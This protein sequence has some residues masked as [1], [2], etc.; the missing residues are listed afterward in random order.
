MPQ[1]FTCLHYHLV[2]STKHRIPQ[3]TN[4][5][6][7]RLWEYLGG[8]VIGAGGISIEIGGTAD[9]VHLLV[10]LRQ[11]PALAD[12][13]REMKASSS[14]WIHAT[15][16][17]MKEFFWQT[18]YGAFTVSHSVM[19]VVR[20]HIENQEVHHRKMSFQDEFRALL[21]KHGIEFDERY[22]WE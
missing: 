20:A 2:Y 4:D 8:I 10:T 5:I 16:P 9:H 14:G 22:L 21:S 6:R 17:A 18:G 11:Q 13:M 19:E 15:F 3:I 1:S 12:F 7:T